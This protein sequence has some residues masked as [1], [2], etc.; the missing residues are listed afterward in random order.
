M[1]QLLSIVWTS[2]ELPDARFRLLTLQELVRLSALSAQTAQ[3]NH[4]PYP[5]S[6]TSSL[7]CMDIERKRL[8][9][10]RLQ[11]V[12][13]KGMTVRGCLLCLLFFNHQTQSKPQA[14]KMF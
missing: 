5:V 8:A 1:P 14:D 3:V 4:L 13:L 2:P 10:C 7:G 12:A 9:V 11:E 6:Y